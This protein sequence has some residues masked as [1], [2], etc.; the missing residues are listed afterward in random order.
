MIEAFLTIGLASILALAIT[1]LTVKIKPTLFG[2]FVEFSVLHSGQ[3]MRAI[4][5]FGCWYNLALW[6]LS[7]DL[8]VQWEDHYYTQKW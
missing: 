2:D 1:E 5:L 7:S 6:T 3:T 4:V 8:L